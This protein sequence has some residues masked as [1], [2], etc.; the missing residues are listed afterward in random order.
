MTTDL[1]K[2][3]ECYIKQHNAYLSVFFVMGFLLLFFFSIGV[4]KNRAII[5]INSFEE[6][7]LFI[8]I[9]SSALLSSITGLFFALERPPEFLIGD[10]LKKFFKN[11]KFEK[12]HK[13]FGTMTAFILYLISLTAINIWDGGSIASPF[14][15]LLLLTASIG[16]YLAIYPHTKYIVGS[17]T[18]IG[19]ALSSVYFCK[20]AGGN[21]DLALLKDYNE[22]PI[23]HIF[24]VLFVT[25]ITIY[26]SNKTNPVIIE[27]AEK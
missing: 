5:V 16:T 8:I 7:T 21:I 23:Y 24:I 13:T 6:I 19:Y 9:I 1:N 2:R 14:G 27:K 26:I 25:A 22:I 15:N 10:F 11:D 17:S 18:V 12:K 4:Y 3:N 20:R